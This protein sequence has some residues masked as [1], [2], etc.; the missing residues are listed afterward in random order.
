MHRDQTGCGAAPARKSRVLAAAAAAAVVAGTVGA[1]RPAHAVVFGQIDD[2]ENGT[3]MNWQHGDN[4][5]APNPPNPSNVADGGPNGAGDNYL[6]NYSLGGSGEHSR[7]IMF[8]ENQ[9]SG[10][11]VAAG[12]T[13]IS[14][15][16][17][18]LGTTNLN[19]RL[20]FEGGGSQ[21]GS[22]N[23]IQ[24]PA[25]AG[26]TPVTFQLTPS[27]VTRL[28]GD[29]TLTET[30]SAVNVLRIL[31]RQAGPDWRGESIV[32]VLGMDAMRAMRLP[33]D[34]NFDGNVNLSDFNTLAANFGQSGRTWQQGDF[35]FDGNVN[36]SDFNLLAANFGQSEAGAP[37]A[38]L[39]PDDWAALASAVPEPGSACLVGALLAPML[40]RRRRA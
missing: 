3:R 2:F 12:V 39:S 13:R 23:A 20:A 5:P 1:A 31:S 6:R 7:Q 26:W 40:V 22:T 33:G 9:W 29:A 15:F 34:A 11:Y 16:M 8:N 10:N 19:M 17:R 32:S 25:G 35:N 27:A 37:G 30:L 21:W 14:G 18:N 4:P 38:G 24:I 36:L 28:N